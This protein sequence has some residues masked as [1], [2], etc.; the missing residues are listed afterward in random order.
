MPSSVEL[1]VLDQGRS[2]G[3][4]PLEKVRTAISQGTI[5]QSARFRV[6]EGHPWLPGAA[7]DVVA[8]LLPTPHLPD[9]P[10]GNPAP[11]PPGEVAGLPQQVRELLRWF[12][13]D[14]DG[15]MGPVGGDYLVKALKEGRL[16]ATAAVALAARRVRAEWTIAAMV[17]PGASA[18]ATTVRRREVP[19][20]P[21][22][23]CKESLA[24]GVSICAACGEPTR[25]APGPMLREQVLAVAAAV[26][27]TACLCVGALLVIRDSRTAAATAARAPEPSSSAQVLAAS[28]PGAETVLALQG[29]GH[30]TALQVAATLTL[31][32]RAADVLALS[33]DRIAVASP[34]PLEILDAGGARLLVSSEFTGVRS[35]VPVHGS[36][37]VL[38]YAGPGLHGAPTRSRRTRATPTRGAET[39]PSRGDAVRVTAVDART[40]RG[41][42]WMEARGASAPVLAVAP[43]R[44]VALVAAGEPRT[45]LVLGGGRVT[46]A[47]HLALDA[48]LALL[49]LDDAG[50]VALGVEGEALRTVS[51]QTSLVAFSS[52]LEGDA[53]MRPTQRILLSERP[54]AIALSGRGDFGLALL[55]GRGEVVRLELTPGAALGPLGRHS[56]V[57]SDP[58]D[59]ALG[60]DVVL[61]ACR[62]GGAV[63]L[64]ADTLSPLKTLDFGGPVLD[65]AVAPDRAQ[66]LL[67]IGAPAS[68]IAVVDLVQR[69]AILLAPGEPITKVRYGLNGRVATAMSAREHRLVVLR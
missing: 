45:L 1:Y 49:A 36:E 61:V 28:G 19:L 20:R 69:G 3:P 31:S 18:G 6:S 14:G 44:G 41:L 25:T 62:A 43:G 64:A 58:A 38:A 10:Q 52:T 50:D 17:F 13:A 68:G 42:S 34:G 35:L 67:A 21:C 27:V 24:P 2:Y 23:Y 11:L 9:P 16:A 56:R 55:A 15:V 65:L 66:V 33:E 12:V 47:K 59:M 29:A 8:D 37:V 57:C 60:M 63:L 22:A 26:A 48:P 4:L 46:G 53:S 54:A 51:P 40:L 7:W 5:G 32:P 30:L 39:L